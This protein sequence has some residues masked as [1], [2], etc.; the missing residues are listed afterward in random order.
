[1]ET[2]NTLSILKVVIFYT[3]ETNSCFDLTAGFIMYPAALLLL[4]IFSCKFTLS[5]LKN[6]LLVDQAQAVML[7]LAHPD[8]VSGTFGKSVLLNNI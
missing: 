7:R 8:L 4:L 2:A 1:M 3:G 6:T 5:L